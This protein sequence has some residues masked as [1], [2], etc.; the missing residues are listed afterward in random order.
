MKGET[1]KLIN[2]KTS[3]ESP[4]NPAEDEEAVWLLG[5]DDPAVEFGV[6]ATVAELNA[7]ELEAAGEDPTGWLSTILLGV[8][9][10]SSA[11]WRFLR[12]TK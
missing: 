8:S 9:M 5:V 1:P 6:F 2:R 4:P 3:S 10:L 7:A 11:P 12:W